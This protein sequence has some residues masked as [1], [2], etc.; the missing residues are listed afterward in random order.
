MAE[1]CG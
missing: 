1:L